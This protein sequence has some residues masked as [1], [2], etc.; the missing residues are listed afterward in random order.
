MQYP[1]KCAW[2]SQIDIR[3]LGWNQVVLSPL[4]LRE[5]A[6]REWKSGFSDNG[7]LGQKS[8]YREDRKTR[9]SELK[10]ALRGL[11]G[12]GLRGEEEKR[13]R[14]RENKQKVTCI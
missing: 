10:E 11:G 7:G 8:P 3:E 4:G 6:R 12:G 9:E 1:Y 14:D 13:D 5:R 2:T